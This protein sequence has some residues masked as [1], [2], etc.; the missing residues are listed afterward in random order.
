MKH[1]AAKIYECDLHCHTNRSDGNSSPKELIDLAAE[2][3]IK[4][5]AITD[6]DMIPPDEIE[7]EE[8]CM[9]LGDYALSKGITAVPGIEIS[10]DTNVED[11]HIIAF[12]C[13]WSHPFFKEL[14]EMT[15]KS[16]TDSYRKVV[17]RLNRHGILLDWD[18]LLY[19]EGNPIRQERLQKKKIFE[20]IAKKGYAPTWQDAKIMV[21]TSNE[22]NVMREKPD[23]CR[24]IEEVHKAGGITILA[25]PYLFQVPVIREGRPLDRFEYIEMLE[26]AGLDGIE[27]C[28]TYDK[29]SYDG[30]RDKKEL[31][32]E[33]KE[34]YEGRL[35][36]ISGGS[37]YHADEKRGV[38]NP[39]MV[40]ECG[41]SLQ[42]FQHHI[43]QYLNNIL[44]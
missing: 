6:H 14:Q 41:V 30:G 27:A 19:N 40:G 28:Y 2:R 35:K 31:E 25:H 20:M 15:I 34:R 26:A 9:S 39:R 1:E 44:F 43:K 13:D 18:E 17:E 21:K 32:L 38:K 42:Y 11:V 16:K 5:I 12:G 37:D 7:T 8:G 24:V 10:C 3:G 36:I 33:I 29:T 4:V 22:Y 23:P